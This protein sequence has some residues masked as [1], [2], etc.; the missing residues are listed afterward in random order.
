ME[1]PSQ[2]RIRIGISSWGDLPGFYPPGIRGADRLAWYARY[3]SLVEVNAS[4]YAV[5]P[6][7]NYARWSETTP[8]DFVFDVKAPA[9]LSSSRLSPDPALFARFKSSYE[10]LRADGKL[11]V[12]LFQFSPSFRNSPQSVAHLRLV[13]SQMGETCSAIEFRHYSWLDPEHADETLEFLA[14]LGLAYVIADEPQFPEDTV[15]PLPAVTA[16]ELAY[17]RLHGRN[18]QG[19]YAD[20]DRRHDYD[21]SE[22]ELTGW[23]ETVSTLRGLAHTVHVLFNNNAGGAGTENALEFARMIG[24]TAAEHP[25]PLPTQPSLF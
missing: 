23:A 6:T 5:L 21:Y 13:A 7:Q 20:R 11:G 17:L 4:Y 14:D 8:G 10:P 12:V 18:H 19:W 22:E 9:D 15:P 1:E 16:P 25:A 3:F 24:Q 2:G